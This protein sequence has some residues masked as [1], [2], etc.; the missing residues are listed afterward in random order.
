MEQQLTNVVAAVW[1]QICAHLPQHSL[2]NAPT[3]VG[4]S[5]G[6]LEDAAKELRWTRAAG[7]EVY[8][9]VLAVVAEALLGETACRRAPLTKEEQDQTISAV[10]NSLN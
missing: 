8:R 3:Q 4:V 10:R 7:P 5:S 9:H 2:G 1:A 6:L